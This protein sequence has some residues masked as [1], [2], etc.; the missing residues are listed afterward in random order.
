MTERVFHDHHIQD[1]LPTLVVE[2]NTVEAGNLDQKTVRMTG[3]VLIVGL[4]HSNCGVELICPDSLHKKVV[5]V[6]QVEQ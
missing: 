2:I 5:V 6:S 3:K 4:D 1:T